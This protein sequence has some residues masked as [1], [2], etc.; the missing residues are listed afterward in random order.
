M[1]VRRTL[2]VAALLLGV[3]AGLLRVALEWSFVAALLSPGPHSGLPALLFG[4]AFLAS[5][6]LAYVA[7]PAVAAA[8]PIFHGVSWAC[9]AFS[10]GRTSPI[11]RPGPMLSAPIR[12]SEVADGEAR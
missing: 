11:R 4:L 3:H 10:R 8:I 7:L 9:R 5:R 12:G 2:L 6:L 1:S